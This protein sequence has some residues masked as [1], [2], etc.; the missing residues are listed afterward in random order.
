MDVPNEGLDETRCTLVDLDRQ[1]VEIKFEE[2]SRG[3]SVMIQDAGVVCNAVLV[4][5][6]RFRAWGDVGR[7]HD[8]EEILVCDECCTCGQRS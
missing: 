2:D 5:V 4:R 7:R 6:K 1:R 8:V 3:S